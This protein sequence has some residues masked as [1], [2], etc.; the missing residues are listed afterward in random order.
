MPR[1]MLLFHDDQCVTEGLSEGTRQALF[2]EFVQWA[3][4]LADRGLYVGSEALAPNAKAKT[5]RRRGET[6]VLDGPFAES[7]EAV[8]GYITVRAE[9]LDDATDLASE[10]PSLRFGWAVEVRELLEIS[11]P[12]DDRRVT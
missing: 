3:D 8:N 10:C 5:V 11:K 7:Q 2:S 1:Y 6:A 4:S 12:T 9:T